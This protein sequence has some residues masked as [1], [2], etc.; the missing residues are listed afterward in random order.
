MK[1]TSNHINTG[2]KIQMAIFFLTILA[3]FAGIRGSAT[4]L[5][6]ISQLAEEKPV[7][8]IPFDTHEVCISYFLDKALAKAELP[9]ENEVTDIP[10]NT[11]VIAK[12]HLNTDRAVFMVME[13][14][15]EVNDIPFDT[16][17]IAQEYWF[18]QIGDGLYLKPEK[19]VNDIPF[20]TSMILVKSNPE[21]KSLMEI[22]SLNNLPDHIYS[23]LVNLIKASL[24]SL[25]VLMSAA[26]I[27]F[28][29]F[30]YVY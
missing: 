15:Q 6:R 30:S 19:S 24:I 12:L 29:F 2:L 5:Y 20:E 3:I 9:A 25:L 21:K 17:E 4:T 10:F 14:E 27:G 16:H 28:L 18:A 23:R 26:I 8:D 1:T 13:S 22:K 11:S 7:N